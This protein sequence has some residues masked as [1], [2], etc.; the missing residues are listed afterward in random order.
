MVKIKKQKKLKKS[1]IFTLF[2]LVFLFFFIPY[3]FSLVE[4][5]KSN[6]VL[7]KEGLNV[8][9]ESCKSKNNTL[10]NYFNYSLVNKKPLIFVNRKKTIFYGSCNVN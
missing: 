3:F 5:D 2:F 8:L 10:I 6:Y 9:I 1:F 7:E 4:L